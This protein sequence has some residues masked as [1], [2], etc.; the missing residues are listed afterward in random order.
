MTTNSIQFARAQLVI[1][2]GVNSPVRAFRQ[3]GG[4][5]ESVRFGHPSGRLWVGA[6]VSWQNGQWQ[7]SK[8][9]MSRSAR[10]LM[11]GVVFV[12]KEL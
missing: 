6:S 10:R 5:P 3:V 8:A 7:L 4:A 1:P 12:P 9:S 11:E 2:G